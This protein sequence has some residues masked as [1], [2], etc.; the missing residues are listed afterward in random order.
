MKKKLA[1]VQ[2]F[3][4]AALFPA[5]AF[6]QLNIGG[7]AITR[8]MINA[9]AGPQGYVPSAPTSPSGSDNE[10]SVTET[11]FSTTY[12]MDGLSGYT[13]YNPHGDQCYLGS[14]WGFQCQPSSLA[15]TPANTELYSA[16]GV[17]GLPYIIAKQTYIQTGYPSLTEVQTTSHIQ[18]KDSATVNGITDVRLANENYELIFHRYGEVVASWKGFNSYFGVYYDRYGIS[19]L[20]ASSILTSAD[21]THNLIVWSTGWVWSGPADC[22]WWGVCVAPSSEYSPVF[23]KFSSSDQTT[24]FGPTSI[25]FSSAV[26]Y[27]TSPRCTYGDNDSP[28]HIRAT[29]WM[30]C[31]TYGL[32]ADGRVG[33]AHYHDEHKTWASGAFV[34]L[35]IV[36]FALGGVGSIATSVVSSGISYLAQQISAPILQGM[37]AGTG[38]TVENSDSMGVG[39]WDWWGGFMRANLYTAKSGNGSGTVVSNPSGINCGGSC[40]SSFYL[41]Q[42]IT[43]AAAPNAGSRFAGWSGACSGTGACVVNLN[44]NASVYADFELNPPAPF[45]LGLGGS[46]ACNYVPLSWSS[47]QYADGYRI[48]RNGADITPYN[49][50]AP[51]NLTDSTVSQG[52]SYS[53]FVRAYNKEGT[54]DSNTVSIT[55]P[56]CPPVVSLS[57]DISSA[58]LGQPVALTWSSIYATACAASGNWSGSKPTGGTET[59]R[60]RTMPVSTFTLTCS[61]PGYSDTKSVSVNVSPLGN[62]VWKEVAPRM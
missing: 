62:P 52:T 4:L 6:A 10:S 38:F 50:Y 26:S 16:K 55:T 7:S 5:A 54:R 1:I 15:P 11:Q 21:G 44:S 24:T 27:T 43:L 29:Y 39:H 53:Y 49:P 17:L 48:Y 30:D 51:I 3:F 13:T 41:G 60:A 2:I 56:Y 23:Q 20:D 19:P 9:G 8:D 46:P 36:S 35:N 47:S 31:D 42:Q 57:S 40:S 58:Y 25:A 37:V 34:F 28:F 45:G 18:Y 59:V 33:H 14:I 32:S 12:N 22:Y 61:N